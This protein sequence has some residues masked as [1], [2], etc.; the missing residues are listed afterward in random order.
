LAEFPPGKIMFYGKVL[1]SGPCVAL[2]RTA[3]DEIITTFFI[4]FGVKKINKHQKK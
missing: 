1:K 4:S 2:G 3:A